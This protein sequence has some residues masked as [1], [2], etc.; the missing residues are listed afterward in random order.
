MGCD[1][2]SQAEHIVDGKWRRVGS[3]YQPFNWRCY[4]I[5]A[6]LAGVRNYSGIKPIAEARGMAPDV[7]YDDG[8]SDHWLGDHSHSWLALDEL[9]SFDYNQLTE[10]RRVTVQVSA[11]A[12]DGARTCAE[13]DGKKMTY[14]EFLGDSFFDELKK[15]KSMGAERIVFGFDS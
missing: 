4:G 6:F 10:D 8:D 14:R 13:G 1:I 11:R 12:W 9:L 5:F 15:L 2:H 3:A 7:D